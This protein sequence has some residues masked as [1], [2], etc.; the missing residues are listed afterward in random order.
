MVRL[1]PALWPDEKAAYRTLKPGVP[2]LP[3]FE[4]VDYKLAGPKMNRREAF[5]DRPDPRAWLEERLGP[6]AKNRK[7]P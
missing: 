6:L 5:I 1:W 3:G 7:K 4:R 2:K